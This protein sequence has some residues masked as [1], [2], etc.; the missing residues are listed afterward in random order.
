[1]TERSIA[2]GSSTIER[3]YRASPARVFAAW[4]S[5]D[6][7]VQWFGGPEGWASYTMDFKVGGGEHGRGK[8][9]EGPVYSY[10]AQYQEIVPNERIV[11]TYT[12]DMDQ[13]RISASVATVELKSEGTGTRLILTEMGA[14]FDGHDKSEFREGGARELMESLAAA[15]AKSA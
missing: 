9:G 5:R 13:T 8:P 11:T 3:S 14:F 12:M 10:D 4:S 15:L 7:K 2:H 1:M 6:A